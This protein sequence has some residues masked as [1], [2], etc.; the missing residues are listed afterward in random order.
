MHILTETEKTVF[1]FGKISVKGG[2][3]N[4]QTMFWN[5]IHQKSTNNVKFRHTK[6]VTILLE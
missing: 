4:K 6:I 2:G 5:Q 1:D 3:E